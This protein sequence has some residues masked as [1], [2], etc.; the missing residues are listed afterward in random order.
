MEIKNIKT[1]L[2]SCYEGNE[3]NELLKF[4][5]NNSLTYL[6]DKYHDGELPE[7]I[8]SIE[9]TAIKVSASFFQENENGK[10]Q[11]KDNLSD[12]L[13]NCSTRGDFEYELLKKIHY[14]IDSSLK[15]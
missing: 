14:K 11:L 4:S 9:D 10:I 5:F 8:L 6:I 7:D 13:E 3:I 2:L 15:G 1:A 12:L